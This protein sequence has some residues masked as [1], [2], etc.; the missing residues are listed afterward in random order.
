MSVCT[1]PSDEALVRR[2][3]EL[4]E[5]GLPLVAD[6]WAWLAGEL[7][8]AVDDTLA[9]LQRLQAEGAI[10][11]IAAVPNHY[12]LGYRHNGMTVWDVDDTEIDRLGALI[13]AQPFV[14]HCYQRP[15]REGWP[16]NLFAMV[17]GRDAS[18][19]EA[20]RNQI[21]A[22]LGSACRANEMLVSSRILKKTGLRLAAQRR[23]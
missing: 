22:L 10:R 6:P 5:A 13:G 4:T 11:R 23:A 15:R 16:Y 8:L 14:S 12:R 17:H 7:G 21:R 20:Y 18:D 3:V 9:L 1:S 2:L 19:I